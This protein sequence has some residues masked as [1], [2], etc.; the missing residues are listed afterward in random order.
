MKT[1][2]KTWK[3]LKTGNEFPY[4]SYSTIDTPKLWKVG[5]VE[6][7]YLPLPA[8][9]Y[10][11]TLTYYPEKDRTDFDK[12]PS[13]LLK[14]WSHA[15]NEM[16]NLP[17][18]VDLDFT[19]EE[20][21]EYRIY[22]ELEKM[23]S[24][25]D[26]EFDLRYAKAAS[27]WLT[28]PIKSWLNRNKKGEEDQDIN[29]EDFPVRPELLRY[30]ICYVEFTDLI[31]FSSATKDVLPEMVKNPDEHPWDIM[32]RLNLIQSNDESA[33]DAL[34]KDVLSKFPEKVAEF[35]GGKVGLAGMFVG[36]VIKAS[37][38]KLNPKIINER[39][40]SMLLE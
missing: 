36:E 11:Y 14:L 30:L 7:E 15:R 34:I 29:I 19:P 33:I 37:P 26:R 6:K 10:P 31:T 24:D 39:V 9:E 1:K 35:K 3:S 27:N 32:E 17:I 4:D 2:P 22:S 23:R 40:R 5:N 38:T 13:F 28:G 12:I 8:D 20:L 25:A 21:F 18:E 16:S